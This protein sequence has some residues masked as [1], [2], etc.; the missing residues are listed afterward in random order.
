DS[1]RFEAGF[2]RGTIASRTTLRG[3]MLE[4]AVDWLEVDS[5]ATL[6]DLGTLARALASDDLPL[7][8]AVGIRLA[9]VPLPVPIEPV[10]SL[11]VSDAYAALADDED[12]EADPGLRDLIDVVGAAVRSRDWH[13][14]AGAAIELLD[15][16]DQPG[17][18]KRVRLIAARRTL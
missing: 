14:V 17:P 12:S 10:P 4:R 3:R 8:E 9:L 16:A 1:A 18:R 11:R 6:N 7:E 2:E 5:Q 15:F 13:Q